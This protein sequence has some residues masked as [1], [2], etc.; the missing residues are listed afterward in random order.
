MGELAECLGFT[1]P[2]ISFPSKEDSTSQTSY[3]TEPT[4]TTDVDDTTVTNGSS[5]D[6]TIPM[7]IFTKSFYDAYAS[8]EK[9]TGTTKF[10]NRP[11]EPPAQSIEEPLLNEMANILLDFI[12]GGGGGCFSDIVEQQYEKSLDLLDVL[13]SCSSKEDQSF[14][15][16]E[17]YLSDE[18]NKI[19]KQILKLKKICKLNKLGFLC[20]GPTLAALAVLIYVNIKIMH[21][22]FWKD[23][24]QFSRCKRN[25]VIEIFTLSLQISG[26]VAVCTYLTIFKNKFLG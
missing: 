6:K 2:D 18:V 19:M 12:G 26:D 23:I 11:T 9:R 13:K 15:S 3:E 16:T 10:W 24:K 5:D 17:D 20:F 25:T 14:R 8:F 21:H 1:A 7:I 22:L 4:D